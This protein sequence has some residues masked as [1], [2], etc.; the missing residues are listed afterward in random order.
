MPR[1]LVCLCARFDL[2]CEQHYRSIV[3][4]PNAQCFLYRYMDKH[5]LL[6]QLGRI[7]RRAEAAHLETIFK[8]QVV[9]DLEK[10]QCDSATARIQL[11]KWKMAEQKLLI[12]MNRV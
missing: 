3:L 1:N 9:A 5:L 2:S 7:R 4:K 10:E 8:H 12:Q 11:N 6:E